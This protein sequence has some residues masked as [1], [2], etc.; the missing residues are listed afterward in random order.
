MFDEF[1]AELLEVAQKYADK[2]M[3]LQSISG[4]FYVSHKR[5]EY[6]LQK[7][8]D[9]MLVMESW[10]NTKKKYEPTTPDLPLVEAIPEN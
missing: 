5:I 8:Y 9:D 3:S 6:K 10:E 7:A 2:G 4:A 1:Q